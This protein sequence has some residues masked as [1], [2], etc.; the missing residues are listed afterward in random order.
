MKLGAA[1]T[2]ALLATL[3]TPSTWPLA[4]AT[5]LL[6]GGIVLVL[7]PIVVLPSPVGLGN[8]LA[9]LLMTVV[10]QG[11]SLEVAVLATAIGLAFVGWIVV[12]GL[13]A[14]TLE[15]EA[16]RVIARE[17][18]ED[19]PERASTASGESAGRGVAWRI[20]IARTVAH[21]PTGGLVLWGAA[22]LIAVAYAEL[23]RPVDVST[24]IVLR[25]LLGAPDV[26]I[27]LGLAWAFGE[28]V[29]A[30]AT[31][32]I[33]LAGATTGVALRDSIRAVIR[34]PLAV[35]AAF[36]VPTVALAFVLVTSSVAAAVAWAAV[37]VAMR[38]PGEL[39]L[40]TVAVVVFVTLW[41]VG[42]LLIAVTA[43]WRA[44]VWSIAHANLWPEGSR[45]TSAKSG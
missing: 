22:R 35:V 5:F 20:L 2:G 43:G 11:L 9:P 1:L 6:R 19:M 33:A 27:L 3:A 26:V 32:R 30:L 16:S 28:V 34:H 24:A 37:R 15:A 31:R 45:P 44:A 29:G 41:L 21:A 12:G 18:N 25:V 13:A 14:A 42:L 8:V 10:F 39:V 36:A 17:A 7:L 40:G 38:P 23:T 4:M